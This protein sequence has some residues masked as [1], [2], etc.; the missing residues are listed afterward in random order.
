MI[1]VKKMKEDLLKTNPT[2]YCST[3]AHLRGKLHMKKISGSTLFGSILY[4]TKTFS[5]LDC[6]YCK[7]ID[8]RRQIYEWTTEKQESLIA[9]IIA[10]YTE[11]EDLHQL[12]DQ[13]GVSA[14]AEDVI[15]RL[16]VNRY[17]D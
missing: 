9:D 5:L 14:A 3:M 13:F 6:K 17:I 10:K 4:M 2:L 11:E 12:L 7:L 16:M 1:N 15:D 8:E